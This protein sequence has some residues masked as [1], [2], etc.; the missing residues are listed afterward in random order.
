VHGTKGNDFVGCGLLEVPCKS[1]PYAVGD[2]VD[3]Q[4]VVILCDDNNYTLSEVF[5]FPQNRKF[6]V[7]GLAEIVDGIE[8]YPSFL[9]SYESQCFFEHGGYNTTATFSN[10]NILIDSTNLVSNRYFF[11]VVVD[12][13]SESS[14]LEYAFCL[15]YFLF[16]LFFY[17]F[18]CSHLNITHVGGSIFTPLI[19]ITRN[20]STYFIHCIFKDF[21]LNFNSSLSGLFYIGGNAS[22]TINTCDF[23]NFQCKGDYSIVNIQSTVYVYHCNINNTQ[24]LNITHTGSSRDISILW[25]GLGFQFVGINNS[26]LNISGLNGFDGGVFYIDDSFGTMFNLSQCRFQSISIKGNGGAIF[27]NSV[28]NFTFN[29]CVFENCISGDGKGGAIYI[30]NTGIISYIDCQFSFNVGMDGAND[31]DHRLNLS[32]EYSASNFVGTCSGSDFPRVLFPNGGNLDLYLV[33]VTLCHK[34]SFYFY[35]FHFFFY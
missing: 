31:I 5:S 26:F 20:L 2:S 22:I 10:L 27:T 19:Y 21:D 32:M 25:N 8:L 33:G 24:F 30:N 15:V 23:I 17:F 28:E 11:E 9:F 7:S 16:F 6:V 1:F 29:S 34:C 14:T 35:F 13:H 3:N 18:F 12:G 4:I